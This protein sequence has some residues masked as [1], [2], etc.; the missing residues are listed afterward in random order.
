MAVVLALPARGSVGIVT[1]MPEP[2][3][4]FF[5]GVFLAIGCIL[6]LKMVA[7]VIFGVVKTIGFG[8]LTLNA[9]LTA[10]VAAGCIPV[11]VFHR[12]ARY[13]PLVP[14]VSYGRF[15]SHSH[16]LFPSLNHR[17]W[18]NQLGIHWASL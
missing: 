17:T 9:L 1:E 15:I 3:V 5:A 11:M 2:R 12:T 14:C 7:I 4:G 6:D 13:V 10:T 18:G 16:P 8:G